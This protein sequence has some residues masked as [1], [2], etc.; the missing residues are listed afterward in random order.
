MCAVC[1]CDVLGRDFA[2]FIEIKEWHTDRGTNLKLWIQKPS[3]I[4]SSKNVAI[5]YG[6]PVVV[7]LA[8]FWGVPFPPK[9]GC[10]EETIRCVNVF[11]DH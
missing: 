4:F 6:D 2:D 10:L 11:E 7:V 8:I 5:L 3:E 9:N 1:F